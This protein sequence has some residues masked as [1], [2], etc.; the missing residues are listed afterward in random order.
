MAL[1]FMHSIV[2]LRATFVQFQKGQI[3]NI[4]IALGVL[5]ARVSIN[6][7]PYKVLKCETNVYYC[8]DFCG[9]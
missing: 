6:V 1:L 2:M 7:L 3:E 4:K 9:R 8:Q 5:L